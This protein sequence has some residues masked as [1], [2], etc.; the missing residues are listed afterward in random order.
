MSS[1]FGLG[2]G[3]PRRR[4]VPGEYI[5]FITIRFI[6]NRRGSRLAEFAGRLPPDVKIANWY[7]QSRLIVASARS[8]LEAVLMLLKGH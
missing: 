1:K 6:D 8:V 7:D 5:R 3:R 2:G 4:S